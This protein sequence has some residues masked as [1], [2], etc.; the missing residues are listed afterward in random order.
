ML[1]CLKCFG[2]IERVN[3]SPC[4][5]STSSAFRVTLFARAL[6][7]AAGGIQV[8]PQPRRR[9]RRP[10]PIELHPDGTGLRAFYMAVRVSDACCWCGG[11][12]IARWHEGGGRGYRKSFLTC[13]KLR[14]SIDMI[15]RAG[16][17]HHQ[18]TNSLA[19][20]PPPGAPGRS[21]P[22]M[23][24]QGRPLVCDTPRKQRSGKAAKAGI[25]PRGRI[26]T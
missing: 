12:R 19:L 13:N 5:A 21:V 24:K 26:N 2:R 18:H 7:Q 4:C 20:F 3:F 23:A 15:K 9:C 1:L 17:G 10:F 22:D 16:A 6:L 11:R 25:R 14:V 8:A